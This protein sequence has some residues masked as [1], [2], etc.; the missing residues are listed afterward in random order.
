MEII[1]RQTF[2][3]LKK[4]RLQ[5]DEGNWEKFHYRPSSALVGWAWERYSN[6]ARTTSRKFSIKIKSIEWKLFRFYFSCL[7]GNEWLATIFLFS[8]TRIS[9]F[10]SQVCTSPHLP[11]IYFAS[12]SIWR[13]RHLRE[14][15]QGKILVSS[16]RVSCWLLLRKLCKLKRIK[17]TRQSVFSLPSRF[18]LKNNYNF[19][20]R[21][22]K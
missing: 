14:S 8:S 12:L 19:V 1:N 9:L 6:K 20:R 7:L 22:E 21:I 18:T 16:S 4:R 2:P 10:H 3:S 13:N 17:L 11:L 15:L 5:V